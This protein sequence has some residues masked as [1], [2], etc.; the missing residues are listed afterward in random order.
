MARIAAISADPKMLRRRLN[1]Q[2]HCSVCAGLCA[3]RACVWS[4]TPSLSGSLLCPASADG[5]PR[6]LGGG[7][8]LL[9]RPRRDFG[10]DTLERSFACPSAKVRAPLRRGLHPK[11]VRRR[12]AAG[13]PAISKR[14]RI[15]SRR[16]SLHCCADQTAQPLLL[17]CAPPVGSRTRCG[18]FLPL[19]CA[20]SSGFGWSPRRQTAS[21]SIASLPVRLPPMP[22]TRRVRS[23]AAAPDRPG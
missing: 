22:R 5:P 17:S 16:G 12:P 9:R 6:G 4:R 7:G 8:A 19:S 10:A 1:Q 15:R 2:H 18:D 3:Q 21:A 14:E 20:G 11:S 13:S 23:H